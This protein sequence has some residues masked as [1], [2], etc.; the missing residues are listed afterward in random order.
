[1]AALL[2][3][4]WPRPRGYANGVSA[5]GRMV[6]VA[7]MI[8][9]DETGRFA[10]DDIA[11]QARQA[12]QALESGQQS[13]QVDLFAP[14]PAA[15]D[16]GPSPLERAVRAINPDALSPRE[17]L[18]LIYQLKQLTEPNGPVSSS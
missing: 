10:G 13:A 15:S 9:W 2:P 18:D 11:S 7:G 3:P 17:A 4:G 6:F 12:L 1:M 16:P 14:A 5:R 8:G